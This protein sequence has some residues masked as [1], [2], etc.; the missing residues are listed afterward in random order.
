MAEQSPSAARLSAFI[1]RESRLMRI[2]GATAGLEAARARLIGAGS[3]RSLFRI[4]GVSQE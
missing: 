3:R 4:E 2:Q 1:G